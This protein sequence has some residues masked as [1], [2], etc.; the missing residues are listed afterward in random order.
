MLKPWWLMLSVTSMMFPG[1]QKDQL[2]LMVAKAMKLKK[3]SSSQAGK[4]YIYLGP[5]GMPFSPIFSFTSI[6]SSLSQKQVSTTE[7]TQEQESF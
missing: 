7:S 2:E 3:S 6:L 1:E 4:F 5:S